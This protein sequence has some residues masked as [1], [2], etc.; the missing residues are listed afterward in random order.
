MVLQLLYSL[1]Y[2]ET[3]IFSFCLHLLYF[4]AESLVPSNGL[5]FLKVAKQA[6]FVSYL[7]DLIIFLLT[8]D[9]ARPNYYYMQLNITPTHK[10][11][12]FLQPQTKPLKNIKT[13]ILN[14]SN[15]FYI[16][17]NPD[18]KPYELDIKTI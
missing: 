8:A 18:S 3:E 15:L 16:V 6:G 12:H 4:S 9:S 11:G 13:L 10:T 7:M 17:N 5:N 14:C 1:Y 2:Y